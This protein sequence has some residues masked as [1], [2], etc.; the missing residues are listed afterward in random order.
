MNPVDPAASDV[1]PFAAVAPFYDLDLEGYDDDLFL[2]RQLASE[3]GG[4]VLELGCGTGRV[5]RALADEGVEVVGVDLSRSMLAIARD[6][7]AGSDVTF[8]EA[9]FRTLDLGRRFPLVLVPLGGLQHMATVDDVVLAL[10]CAAT[11]F[12]K[13]GSYVMEGAGQT[14]DAA[15]M[16]AFYDDL[17]TSYPIIS[18]EDGLAEDDWDGWVAMTAEMGGRVQLVGDDLFVTNSERLALGLDKGAANSILVKVNQIGTLTETLEAVEMAHKAGYTAVMSHRS[19]ETEDSTI[20]DLAV[21]TNCGQIKTGS[22]SRSDRMAKYNQL[23]RIEEHL[24]PAGR[25]GGR[26]FL[27]KWG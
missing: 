4:A 22:T 15:G 1:D 16:I 17:L 11:E 20:A 23:I 21:A 5:A 25:Y 27:E 18:I 19:G 6:R 2:Y 10:D 13:N 3:A 9:D 7:L 8:H 24:G 26:A 12:F 14:L